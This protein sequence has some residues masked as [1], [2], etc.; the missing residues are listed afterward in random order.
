MT[1]GMFWT[2]LLVGLVVQAVVIYG[3][4]RLALV[5]DRDLQARNVARDAGKAKVAAWNATKAKTL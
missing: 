4:I 1:S 5:H 3:A 2:A